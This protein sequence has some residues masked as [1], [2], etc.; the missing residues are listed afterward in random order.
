MIMTYMIQVYRYVFKVPVVQL[1]VLTG[2][3]S[4]A[5]I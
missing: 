4:C 3:G 1:I 2:E 5:G